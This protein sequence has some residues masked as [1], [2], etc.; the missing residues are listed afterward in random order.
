MGRSEALERPWLDVGCRLETGYASRQLLV[1]L[2]YERARLGT[3]V[4]GRGS[5]AGGEPAA[6]ALGP[7]IP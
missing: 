3:W 4:E 1:F 6:S 7:P 2:V 5:R